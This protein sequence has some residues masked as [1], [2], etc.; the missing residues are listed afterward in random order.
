M[1]VDR[2]NFACKKCLHD[3]LRLAKSLGHSS[4]EAEHVA[5]SMLR[6]GSA[7]VDPKFQASLEQTIWLHLK[8][9]PRAYGLIKIDFGQRMQSVFADLESGHGLIF[10]R[11]LWQALVRQSTYIRNALQRLHED[12]ASMGSFVEMN[13]G[14]PEQRIDHAN[15]GRSGD[16]GNHRQPEEVKVLAKE[17]EASLSKFTLDLTELAAQGELEPVLG[18]EMEARRLFE[19]LGRKRKNNPLLL[20]DPGV[21]KTAVVELIAQKIVSGQV[22]E[23]MKSLRVLSL[24]VGALLAGARYRGEFEERL[25][26]VVDA[27]TQLKPNVVLFIDEIHMLI[28]TGNSEG[29]ADAANLLKPALARGEI[30]CIG[31]TTQ[32]EYKKFFKRDQALD[33]RFQ[34]LLVNEPSEVETLALLRSLRSRYEAHHGIKISDAALRLAVKLAAKFLAH[35]RFPD[36]AIDIVDEA[37]SRVRIDLDSMPADLEKVKAS[38]DGLKIEY[39]A[40]A[41]ISN[42]ER[43]KIRLEVEIQKQASKV[44]VLTEIWKKHRSAIDRLA[45]V[46]NKLLELESLS[47]SV[48]TE[49]DFGFAA[50]IKYE[51]IPEMRRQ[52]EELNAILDGMESEHSFLSRLVDEGVISDIISEWS[53]VPRDRLTDEDRASLRDLGKHLNHLVFGQNH[54][55]DAIVR[56]IKRSRLGIGDETKPV[57]VFLFLGQTG[58]GKTLTAKVLARQMFGSEDALVRFDLSEF[59]EAHAVSRLIGAPPGYI[60]HEEGGEL[61]DAVRKRPYSVILFD[62]VEKAHPKTFDI[63]LQIFDD[64]RLTDSKGE[65]VSFK[66][67]IIILTSN[68]SVWN[69]QQGDYREKD[70]AVR[71]SLT[72]HFRPEFVNRIDEVVLFRNLDEAHFERILGHEVKIL[73]EKLYDRG[74]RIILLPSIVTELINGAMASEFGGRALK[75]LFKDLVLDSVSDRLLSH[76][77]IYGA[78]Q[79]GLN[80]HGVVEWTLENEPLKYLPSGSE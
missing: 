64:G 32:S 22:P 1:D 55:I 34:S 61:T 8:A 4:V 27:L 35:R 45:E 30:L 46:E 65:V 17:L 13:L 25:K 75:R 38:L 76:E 6:D 29:G 14:S 10:E 7:A 43:D 41:K 2:Y 54:A 9:R 56:T 23:S 59:A 50:D 3:G 48:R 15:Q 67:A 68:L 37:S 80:A 49:G 21:G 78:W 12:S 71:Q 31:A 20:G 66:N 73:N 57:G 60:G 74:M 47:T 18:R 63:M 62:E 36:K 79:L 28:G 58:V 5:V 51:T 19:I 16:Q 52:A 44:T 70:D 72:S 77:G 53:G 69:R 11:T 39:E 24:D 33:R 42:N 40:I 26:S